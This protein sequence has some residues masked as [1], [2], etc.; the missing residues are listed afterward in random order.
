MG[1]QRDNPGAE[2]VGKTLEGEAATSGLC[3]SALALSQRTARTTLLAVQ[4]RD[5]ITI[6]GNKGNN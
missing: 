6:L 4:F 2:P 3:P 5:V 1:V